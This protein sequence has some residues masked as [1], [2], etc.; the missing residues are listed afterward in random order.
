MDWYNPTQISIGGCPST[1]REDQ[2]WS[3]YPCRLVVLH[4][5]GLFRKCSDFMTPSAWILW[6]GRTT[7]FFWT[8]NSL[9]TSHHPLYLILSHRNVT[10]PYNLYIPWTS[11]KC[12][13]T[14]YGMLLRNVLDTMPSTQLR[15]KKCF[16]NILLLHTKSQ[17][18]S[19]AANLSRQIPCW[20]QLG[21]SSYDG[22]M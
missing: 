15:T 12:P 14:D 20:T 1:V 10:K 11:F 22:R 17:S 18:W 16:K 6:Q 2:W 21:G 9:S 4:S 7:S 5:V 8:W 13:G 19:L 3:F